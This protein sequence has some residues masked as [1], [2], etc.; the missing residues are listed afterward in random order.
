MSSI[1][2]RIVECMKFSKLTANFYKRE[3]DKFIDE[4][5][6][7]VVLGEAPITMHTD[8]EPSTQFSTGVT[9]RLIEKELQKQK[10]KKPNFVNLESRAPVKKRNFPCI[11]PDRFATIVHSVEGVCRH[12]AI[13]RR[14]KTVIK[15]RDH[16][17]RRISPKKLKTTIK[18]LFT[19][20]WKL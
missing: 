8:I 20:E 6:F 10:W 11:D 3:T 17:R 16:H 15:A 1:T 18:C 14:A 9:D 5:Q 2:R 19:F 12:D 7:A 13:S 4:A